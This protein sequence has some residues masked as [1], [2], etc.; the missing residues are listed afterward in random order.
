MLVR[1]TSE[2][3][4]TM[5]DSWKKLND[6]VIELMQKGQFQ[7]ALVSANEALEVVVKEYGDEQ[8]NEA[9]ILNNLGEMYHIM[10]D[11]E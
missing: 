2:R 9:L 1:V 10:R 4:C 5:A 6:N 8:Q 3:R 11:Y 7:E